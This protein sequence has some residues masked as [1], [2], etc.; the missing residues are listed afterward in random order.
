MLG[1]RAM[2]GRAARASQGQG[3]GKPWRKSARAREL[4]RIW[5]LPL[6]AGGLFVAL[7]VLGALDIAPTPPMVALDAGLLLATALYFPLRYAVRLD[8]RGRLLAAVFALVWFSFLEIALVRRVLPPPPLLQR[9]V[10]ASEAPVALGLRAAPARFDLVV[11]G[12]L[13]PGRPGE[14]RSARWTL[15]LGRRGADPLEL[16]G[17]LFETR[18]LGHRERRG[19]VELWRSRTAALFAIDNPGRGDLEVLSLNVIGRAEP[20]LELTLLPATRAP[21]WVLAAGGVLL[22]VAALAFDR[23]TGAGATAASA[24]ILTGAAVVG[25]AAF[26]HLA[27]PAPGFRELFAA[28]V[29][30]ALLGGP[31]GG[32]LAW[33][34]GAARKEKSHGR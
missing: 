29:I 15:Q 5:V 19:P 4:L 25:T 14:P 12:Q 9:S 17:D 26:V 23:A 27:E 8:G 11:R 32:L 2:A 31:A 21:L 24:T 22:A 18:A 28:L 6:A 1:L 13:G 20:V 34:G 7:Y 10:A 30:G 16:H 33:L 3:A